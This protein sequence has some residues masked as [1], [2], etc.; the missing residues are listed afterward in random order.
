M[1]KGGR[2]RSLKATARVR[3][4]SGII[5]KKEGEGG[6][7]RSPSKQPQD[8]GRREKGRREEGKGRSVWDQDAKRSAAIFDIKIKTSTN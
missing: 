7:Y 3:I 8:G 2:Y 1:T 4:L 5:Y 6:R